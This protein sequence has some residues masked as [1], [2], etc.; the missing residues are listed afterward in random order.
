MESYLTKCRYVFQGLLGVMESHN[1]HCQMNFHSLRRERSDNPDE[2]VLLFFIMGSS[3][4]SFAA[5]QRL[6]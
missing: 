6:L 3:T 4:T 5:A 2:N 1:C